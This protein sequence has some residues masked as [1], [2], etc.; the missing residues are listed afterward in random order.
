MPDITDEQLA[1]YQAAVAAKA[2]LET[3]K[4]ALETEKAEL[5]G[6]VSELETFKSEAEKSTLTEKERL[7]KEVETAKTEAARNADLAAQAEVK[8]RQALIKAAAASVGFNNPEDA[9]ALIPA[10]K[11]SK[12]NANIGK[13][14]ED[15]AKER[16]YL[17]KP[18]NAGGGPRGGGN[19]NPGNQ[20]QD[21]EVA[22]KKGFLE[23]FSSVANN[24]HFP[25]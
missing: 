19:F 21:E 17:L 25:S 8:A 7:E 3:E 5:N 13:L 1:E 16:A 18:T 23:G 22:K 6:K 11:I 15:L 12:D 4:A 20:K 9:V 10:D 24:L 14:V 2:T